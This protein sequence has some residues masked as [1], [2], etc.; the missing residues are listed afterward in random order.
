MGD[1][2]L[3]PKII[4]IK[5]MTYHLTNTSFIFVFKKDLKLLALLAT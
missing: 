4:I 5:N 2:T 1:L 3:L